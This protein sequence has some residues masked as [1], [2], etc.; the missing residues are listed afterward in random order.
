M[1]LEIGEGAMQSCRNSKVGNNESIHTSVCS[2]FGCGKCGGDFAV[3]NKRVE[4]EIDLD[5]LAMCAQNG[6]AQCVS[7]EVV[8]IH[9]CIKCG[10]AEINGIGTSFNCRIKCLGRTRRAEQLGQGLDALIRHH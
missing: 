10:A 4:C 8:G 2:F 3:S 1:Q 9:S 5:S 7:A 6:G